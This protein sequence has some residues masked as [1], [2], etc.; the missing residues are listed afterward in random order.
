MTDHM[1]SEAI[2]IHDADEVIDV[3]NSGR[4][5]PKRAVFVSVVALGSIFVDGWM[6]SSFGLATV[7]L[8]AA[9]NL[10]TGNWGFHSLPFLTA[11]ILVGAIIGGL[12]GGYLTDK[13]GRLK[14]FLI[15]LFLLVGATL[16]EA[17]AP[18]VGLL[19][20]WRLLMGVGVGLDVPVA[21][22]FISEYSAV[23]SKGRSVNI[24]QV[25]STGA[26][27][28]AFF[29]MIPFH[30]AGVGQSLWRYAIGLGAIPAIVVLVLRFIYSAESPMWAAKHQGVE[31]AVAI[32]R[33]NY[34]LNGVELQV[35]L[36]ANGSSQP[37]VQ[38][39]VAT[40]SLLAL[41]R[42]PYAI[43]TLLTSILVVTQAVEY[44]AISIY[45]PKIMVAL[46]G[47]NIILVLVLSGA[48]NV[49]GVFGALGC[50]AATQHLGLRRL[51]IIGYSVTCACLI[52]ISG[53]YVLLAAPISAILI[54]IFYAG[55][56]FGPG[57]AGTAMG[58]L[59][60]PTSIRGIGGGYT[61]A[62]TRVG[63]IIG[64]YAFPVLVAAHGVRF[65][66]GALALAPLIGIISVVLIHW[67]PIGQDVD[68]DTATPTPE[69]VGYSSEKT[70][71][72]R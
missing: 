13:V 38:S 54:M 55:H 43:R 62:I 6:L 70:L 57:Y 72:P 32:L 53:A 52:I 35:D 46:F 24:A 45:T 36:S 40:G 31:R 69:L 7:Q 17:T 21:L 29:V 50:V 42:R 1:S 39:S 4:L 67:D 61:Q 27:A 2:V 12:G 9:F 37:K 48:A 34:E 60:Y 71:E 26:G 51:A 20:L 64:S 15:D 68:R 49:V 3:I 25:L 11:A 65:T 66:I 44:Y 58:T 47:N 8:K 16:L 63:G 22:A 10:G 56:N 28:L 41:F 59:S 18:S 5:K 19:W 30:W 23:S 14:M 33:R